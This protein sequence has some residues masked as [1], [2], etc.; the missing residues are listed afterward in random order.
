MLTDRGMARGRDRR[1][2]SRGRARDD[3]LKSKTVDTSATI[4]SVKVRM[5]SWRIARRAVLTSIEIDFSP[6]VLPKS[7]HGM[8]TLEGYTV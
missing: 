3:V 6:P 7:R 8:V 4:R 1:S 2:P 5:P